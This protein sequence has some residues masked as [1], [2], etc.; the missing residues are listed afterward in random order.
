MI[1]VDATHTSH[2][3]AR[4]GI[5]QLT[6]RLIAPEVGGAD[7]SPVTYD[8]FWQA[9]RT[10]DP[11]ELETARANTASGGSRRAKWSVGQKWRGRVARLIGDTPPF[12]EGAD[13]FLA[14]EIFSK[15]VASTYRKLFT[16]IDGPR[17]A[18]FHD[19]IPITH[20]EFT[21]AKTVARFPTYLEELREFDGVAAVSQHSRD[22]LAGFWKW[23]GGKAPPVVAIT[24]GVAVPSEVPAPP[25]GG[26][27]QVLSVGTIEG[28]KNHIALL[29]AAE[30]LWSAGVQFELHIVGVA[31]P[32]TAAAAIARIDG[33][34]AGGR[35]LHFHGSVDDAALEARWSACRFSVYPSL[36]EGYGLP[37]I[38]SVARGRPCICSAVGAT[39]EAASGGGCLALE[40]VD[41]S[42]LARGIRLLLE[43]D[44]ALARIRAEAIARPRRTWADYQ[45]DIAEWIE[46]LR[47]A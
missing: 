4:T 11:G 30:S 45:R 23:A 47:R 3:T 34:R 8:K 10:L 35:A 22:S 25:A 26:V 40:S 39:G 1:L 16:T 33:L 6:R 20:P 42:S 14:P 31:R 12:P 41:P 13:A 36:T 29:D 44:A 37:V 27:P 15:E 32:E 9:W 19:T 18:L 46:S 28:R 43:D 24:P 2:S 17:V 5:Q 21:P 38:E 7:F